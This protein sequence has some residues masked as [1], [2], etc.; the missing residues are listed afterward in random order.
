MTETFHADPIVLT[1][2]GYV[3]EDASNQDALKIIEALQKGHN[4]MLQ[5]R[6][7]PT[8]VAATL[9][10]KA[11]APLPPPAPSSSATPAAMKGTPVATAPFPT[12]AP[13]SARTVA[14]P[15]I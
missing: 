5:N 10:G 1:N 11:T 13:S 9:A 12:S 2:D 8:H 7:N 6:L 3:D 14:S 15:V 4:E